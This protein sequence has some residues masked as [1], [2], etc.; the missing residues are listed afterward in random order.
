MGS[1]L[2]TLSGNKIERGSVEVHRGRVRG[3][4]EEEE[5]V[6]EEAT[7]KLRC[8]IST[9]LWE[10]PLASGGGES[11]FRPYRG[12]TPAAQYCGWRGGGCWWRGVR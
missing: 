5:E 10:A 7:A 9:G 4:E 6:E 3:G 1:P 8:N 11:A 2:I 12:R